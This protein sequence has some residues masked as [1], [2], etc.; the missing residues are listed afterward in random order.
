MEAGV[1]NRFKTSDARQP[2]GLPNIKGGFQREHLASILGDDI[3]ILQDL[4]PKP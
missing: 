3:S 2:G 4:F 1:R